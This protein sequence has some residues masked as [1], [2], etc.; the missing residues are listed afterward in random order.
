MHHEYVDFIFFQVDD[1]EGCDDYGFSFAYVD[2]DTLNFD[3]SLTDIEDFHNA[4]DGY[5]SHKLG[6][7][8]GARHLILHWSQTGAR[9]VHPMHSFEHAS[10]VYRDLL[11]EF[12]E[13]SVASEESD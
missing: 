11:E 6:E 1:W 13:W 8:F 4:A 2:V 7:H 10:T 9:T 12:E 3:T 5:I